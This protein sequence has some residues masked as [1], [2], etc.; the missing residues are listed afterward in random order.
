M[1]DY[2]CNAT[3]VWKGIGFWDHATTCAG[4]KGSVDIGEKDR[5]V[6][7]KLAE[8]LAHLASRPREK[9]KREL[10]YRHNAL[11]TKQPVILAD[12][13]N[14]WNDIITEDQIECKEELARNWEVVLRKEI[15][16]GES[17]QDDRPIEPHFYIGYTYTDSGWG[18]SGAFRGGLNGGSYVWDSPVHDIEDL[19]KLHYPEIVVDYETTQ[20]TVALAKEVLGDFLEV[21]L[22]GVWWWSFG[23]TF[24]LV[25]LIGIEQMMLLPYDNPDLLHRM[26]Q[27]LMEG[28]IRKLD[29]LEANNFLSLNNE[30]SYIGSGG[31][32]YTGEL[33]KGNIVNDGIKT[34]DMWGFAESQETCEMSPAMF[35]EFFFKY[36]LPILSRFGLNCYGCCEPLDERFHIIKNIPNL[37]RVSVSAWADKQRMS[38]MLEDRYIYSMK[39]NPADL[40]VN[41]MD[42]DRVRKDIR[43]YLEITKDNIVEIIMKDNHTLGKNPKNITNWVKI[44]REEV[45][46]TKRY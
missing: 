2:P 6:L 3:G 34:T 39:P 4:K 35:E 18:L 37:R 33:P 31:I 5:E 10:W 19:Q 23:M 15:F 46:R 11:E 9:E 45:E 16:W 26:M 1:I 44:V 41:E 12:P 38:D 14:G 28:N 22:R 21:I 42:C 32:G 25:I 7:R 13:E 27:F 29:F 36:Q 8:K 24:D 30:S 20:K 40:A 43:R 17:M